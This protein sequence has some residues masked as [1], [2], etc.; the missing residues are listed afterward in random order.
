M[1]ANTEKVQIKKL[2]ARRQQLLETLVLP[3]EGIAGSLVKINRGCWGKERRCFTGQEP[4]RW[5]LTYMCEGKKRVDYVSNDVV[6]QVQ[7]QVA[8]GNVYKQG[9]AELMS[10]NAQIALLERR[11]RRRREAEEKRRGRR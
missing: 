10:I 6:E 8:E 2:R 7:R 4:P 3:P 1:E 9:V 11:E 5:T